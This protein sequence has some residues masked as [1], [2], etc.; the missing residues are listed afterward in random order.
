MAQQYCYQ[1]YPQVRILLNTNC[2][3]VIA[4]PRVAPVLR[5]A[6]L[7]SHLKFRFAEEGAFNLLYHRQAKTAG[8]WAISVESFNFQV[9]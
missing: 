7:L 9:S 8:D 2:A 6:L 5:I 4:A 1:L 3:V